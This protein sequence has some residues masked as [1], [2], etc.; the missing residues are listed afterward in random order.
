MA[1]GTNT[2]YQRFAMLKMS[3]AR[4]GIILYFSGFKVR[5][6]ADDDNDSQ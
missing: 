2:E 4:N 5:F 1:A 6:T 3:C